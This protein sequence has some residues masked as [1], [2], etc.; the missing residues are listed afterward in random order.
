M[1]VA[2]TKAAVLHSFSCHK[3]CPSVVLVLATCPASEHHAVGSAAEDVLQSWCLC[4]MGTSQT[5]LPWNLP[6]TLS[7]FLNRKLGTTDL[8]PS[9]TASSRLVSKRCAHAM[10]TSYLQKLKIEKVKGLP[11]LGAMKFLSWFIQRLS[12]QQRVCHGRLRLGVLPQWDRSC[13][14]DLLSHPVT[15]H[16]ELYVGDLIHN[17]FQTGLRSGSFKLNDSHN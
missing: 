5:H 13:R 14:L 11:V 12:N 17:M 10:P 2:L 1:P 3:A 4:C 8:M 6:W 15:V 7:L 16:L 9:C